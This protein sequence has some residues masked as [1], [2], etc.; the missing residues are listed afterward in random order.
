VLQRAQ[1]K[2]LLA[3]LDQ[4]TIDALKSVL[5][6]ETLP[7][8]REESVLAVRQELAEEAEKTR[9]RLEDRYAKLV[10]D[11]T[12]EIDRRI[13]D[14]VQRGTRDLTAE[15]ADERAEL[16]AERQEAKSRA[17]QAERHLVALLQQLLPAGKRTYLYNAGIRELS[18]TEL[19]TT[20]ARVQ[21]VLKSRQTYSERMVACQT[22]PGKVEGKTLFWLE[23]LSPEGVADEADPAEPPDRLALPQGEPGEGM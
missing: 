17:A 22:A 5:R 23:A 21:L 13:E 11:W 20:L 14:G 2:A 4:T 3:Q 15:L 19:N 10:D 18:L 9:E 6:E 16:K 7:A 12:D 1:A 8:L